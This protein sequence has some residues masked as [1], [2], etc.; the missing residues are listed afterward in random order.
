MALRPIANFVL[1]NGGGFVVRGKVSWIDAKGGEK[2]LTGTPGDITLG[3]DGRINPGELGVPPHS[4]VALFADVMWGDDVEA[5]Q[6]FEYD[7]ACGVTATYS[8]T[9]TVRKL[10]L[11]GGGPVLGLVSVE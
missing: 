11:V 6:V 5:N 8:I 2:H 7:P 3:F 4:S 1:H 10:P 9:G